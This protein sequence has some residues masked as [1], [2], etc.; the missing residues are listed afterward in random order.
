MSDEV[1]LRI[2]KSL[3]LRV[4]PFYSRLSIVEDDDENR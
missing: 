1:N 2:K 3:F 4:Q